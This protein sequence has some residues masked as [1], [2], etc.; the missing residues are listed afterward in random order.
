M[1]MDWWEDFSFSLETFLVQN[2][3]RGTSQY[4]LPIPYSE[5]NMFWKKRESLYRR[6]FYIYH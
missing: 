3:S 2:T 1:A 4:Q 6:V 5:S